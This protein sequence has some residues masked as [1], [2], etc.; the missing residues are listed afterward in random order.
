MAEALPV[1]KDEVKEVKE[2]KNKKKKKKKKQKKNNS[3]GVILGESSLQNDS[4]KKYP[5]DFQTDLLAENFPNL[6]HNIFLWA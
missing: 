6:K 5:W 2:T 1:V 4:T 3:K